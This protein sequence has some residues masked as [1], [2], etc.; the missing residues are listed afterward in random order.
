MANAQVRGVGGPIVK[1]LEKNPI[2]F[3]VYL[4]CLMRQCCFQ[5]LLFVAKVAIIPRKI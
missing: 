5:E 3:R 2:L 1:H 4:K